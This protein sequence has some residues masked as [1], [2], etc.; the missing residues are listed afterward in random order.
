[1]S[2]LLQI[3]AEQYHADRQ[4][5]S[6]SWLDRLKQSPAH[7]RHYLDSAKVETK[8]LRV[9][10]IVHCAILEP[11]I[12]AR[13][14]VIKPKFDGRTTV[15]KDGLTEWEAANAGKLDVTVAEFEMAKGIRESVMAHKAA[16]ALLERVG[17]AEQSAFWTNPDTDVLC[18]CRPDYIH[19][20][21]VDLK[22]TEDASPQGFAR[23]IAKYRYHIQAAQYTEGTQ[24]ERFIIVA[25]EKTP[26]YG[27]AVYLLG[28]GDVAK[29]LETRR[30][31][32]DIYAECKATNTWPSY[33]QE[34]QPIT[35]P[36][37]A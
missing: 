26:P 6:K 23:S 4:H 9:G 36:A 32:L 29:G 17:N 37:W 11:E 25:A 14:F 33:P 10:R 35:L 22:T 5:V 31:E 30:R 24:R 7:L 34:I 20:F 21:V 19:D 15:G 12:F 16:R 13:D 18:K 8:A 28:D 1:M 3:P 27:V 2:E